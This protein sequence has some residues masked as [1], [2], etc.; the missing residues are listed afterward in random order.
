MQVP[1]RTP[2]SLSLGSLRCYALRL[3]MTKILHSPII[4]I[5]AAAGGAVAGWYVWPLVVSLVIAALGAIYRGF[6]SILYSFVSVVGAVL[7][8][9]TAFAFAVSHSGLRRAA[10]WLLIL[11]AVAAIIWSAPLAWDAARVD[12]RR[13]ALAVYGLPMLWACALGFYGFLLQRRYDNSRNA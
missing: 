1:R 13:L 6:P 5:P 2:L 8:G 3:T 4:A 11:S 7:G 9:V 10:G 12:G